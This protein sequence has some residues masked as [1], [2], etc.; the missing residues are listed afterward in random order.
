MLTTREMGNADKS[1]YIFE[2]KSSYS[3]DEK[4]MFTD[5]DAMFRQFEED[6]FILNNIHEGTSEER[7]GRFLKIK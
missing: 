6:S 7:L 4:V 3:L 1:G 5:I 2:D